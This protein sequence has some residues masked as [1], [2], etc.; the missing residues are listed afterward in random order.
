MKTIDE[1]LSYLHRLDV[2]LWIED[3][4]LRCNAPEEALTPA[5]SAQIQARKAE[6][7]Q[8]LKDIH[9]SV[10]STQNAIQPVSRQQNLP[11]SFAQQ[12]LWFLDQLQLGSPLY[13][14]TSAL[15]L[16]GQLNVEVLQR[17][18]NA[19][20]QRHEVLRTTFQTVEGQ[21]VQVIAPTLTVPLPLVNLQSL[22]PAEQDAQVLQ[23]A[24]QDAQQPFD[25]TQV[26]LVR[27]TLLRLNEEEHVALFTMH[28]IVSDGWSI[29][30]LIRELTALYEAFL[31]GEPSPLA[32]LTIQYADFAVW[33]RQW[34]QGETLE[35]QLAYWKRQIGENPPVLQ[36]LSDRP[37]PRVQTFRGARHTF[38]LTRDLTT[39]LK[40]LSRK[41]DTTLFMTL[42][43]AFK[44]LLY[45]Y[46]GQTD[47]LVGSPIAN[48]NRTEIEGLIGFFV[49]NLVLRS[50]VSDNPPFQQLLKQVREVTL[51]AYA[52]QDLPF[53]YLVEQL[54][55]QRDL[56]YS[57]I[58][59]VKFALANT[60]SED[61]KL[62]GLTLSPLKQENPTAKLDLSLDMFESDAGLI[63]VFEY[64][65]DLFEAAT[66]A[67][68]AD[69]FQTLLQGI[70]NHPEQRLS[71]LPLLTEAEQHQILH[72]W[73]ETGAD[74]PEHQ[75]FHERFAAQVEQTPDA[76]ALIFQ[77]QH[78]Q[79]QQLTYAAL[80]Q[81]ANQLAHRLIELGVQPETRVGLYVDRSLEMMI[82]LLGILKAGGAYVPLDP[83][84][85]ADRL[86][87]MLID[88]QVS[89]VCSDRA[90]RAAVEALVAA[91]SGATAQVVIIDPAEWAA[92][93]TTNPP[94]QVTSDNLAYLIY[95]SGST[96]QPKGVLVPH[97][98][99]SN[100]TEAKIQTCEVQPDSRVL[101]FFSISFD[102]SIPEWIMALG[103]GAT[104]C[105]GT[106]E[107]L[108][109]GDA[110]MHLLQEQA[111]THITIPPSA[112]AV[113]ARQEVPSLRLIL[114]GGEACPPDLIEFWSEGRSF[115]NAYGPTEVTVNASMVPCGN[116][117]PLSPT[118]R[119]SANKQ[120]YVLD[121]H[122]Q[123]V[124]VGVAGELY[125]GG[126]GLARGYLHRPDKTAEVFLPNP[127]SDRPG[128]RLYKTGD[129]VRYQPDGRIEFLGRLDHQVKI[130]GFRIEPGEIETLL[131]QHPEVRSSL[132]I[133][134]EDQ[135]GNKRL[136]AYI[137]PT[138]GQTP[139][140]RELRR[141][142]K[143]KLPDYMVPTAFAI[144]D[145]LPLSPNGKVDRQAL[146]LPE[147]MQ[148]D[149][150][151]SYVTPRNQTEA[152]L[153]EIFAQVLEVLQ[154]GIHDDFFELGGHS[155]LVTRVIARLHR[156][157]QVQLTVMNLFETPT[158]AGLA[159]SIETARSSQLVQ[160][161]NRFQ[162]KRREKSA[163]GESIDLRTEAV[164]D[165]EI[166]P[167]CLSCQMPSSPHAIFLTGATGFVGAFLLHELLQQTNADL[168][169]LVRS[170]STSS[171]QQR[172][173]QCL[174]SYRL[175]DERFRTRIIPVIGD[176]SKPLLGLSPTQFQQL[177]TTV[178]VIYHS[179][180]WVHHASPYSSL[181]AA[182]VL[183]TQEVLR[184]AAQ[185]KIKP[186]HFISAISVFSG[187]EVCADQ[188]IREQSNPEPPQGGY[189]QSKWVA[190]QLVRLAGD[191]GLPVCIYRLGR[192]SGHSQTGVFNP[193]DFLYRLIMGCVEL[194]GAPEGDMLLNIIPIDYASQAIIHLSQQLN[195]IGKAFH[196]IHPQPV[197]ANLLIEK[198]RSR[199]YSI[200]RLTSGEWI[201]QLL[202]I[203]E[204]SPHH[205]L[206]PLVSFF[207]GN[208][209]TLSSQSHDLKFDCKQTIA[210]LANTSINCPP[211]GDR[212]LDIYISYLIEHQFL[213]SSHV[214]TRPKQFVQ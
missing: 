123:A 24:S 28:H 82:G 98:G 6:I 190:E 2:K 16:K 171:G 38:S 157:F 21:P 46:T 33:Q 163:N 31:R 126:V 113:L 189:N 55:P 148:T 131:S 48:R 34:L 91:R 165:P 79:D 20:V 176:L 158:V 139:T 160:S 11:L 50:D 105:L 114:V 99:L 121:F 180:A 130:R 72:T 155:L 73:N 68:T 152:K 36:L 49:N 26:P 203:A 4:R 213:K 166:L 127:F 109:P 97:R 47:I 86:A 71:E 144:L 102:A 167:D 83:A 173:Q 93:P 197:S 70:V 52:H 96:G 151:Q 172:L 110:L 128:S 191:R 7:M 154:V 15:R 177:A 51:E 17:S 42:L 25:L 201:D 140:S 12:R 115:I 156:V 122:L 161:S 196:L 19:V 187:R 3:D 135:P 80:N 136:V 22:P 181:K 39:A 198:L 146:P 214:D 14:I 104:L 137:I 164:L 108:M 117:V 120:L 29:G 204:R 208:S 168:Y 9:G 64:N 5:L 103:C 95:T 178:E 63:G 212:L 100:L 125:I 199:G 30:I 74:Y 44:A 153:A 142:L 116:G 23:L 75:C 112:L 43:A 174:D 59:Q 32:P 138:E 54:Q 27:L 45:R 210:G 129:L 195:S 159:E 132:V 88:S 193:N 8:V 37:R 81:S 169:C 13:N 111:I 84:Y 145:A 40:A 211:I 202:F 57:P 56:S 188:I 89:V 162:D 149:S 143:E 134:R 35:K 85:P 192:I 170:D 107:S 147:G 106:L 185:G 1:F 10:S 206:Y 78:F 41:A 179:G 77:D 61:L 87:Y 118:L 76:I 150:E 67:H 209:Q 90:N 53:E 133:V 207:T 175:W 141:F 183:G 124:P 101:Q 182:N 65:T 58:F 94:S 66:I 200:Q 186:V 92:L 184:F 60:P 69:H 18:L 194:G 62:P 119:P 205:A